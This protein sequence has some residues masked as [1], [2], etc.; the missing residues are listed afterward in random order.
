MFKEKVIARFK[1]LLG[2]RSAMDF[3]LKCL[4]Y[5]GHFPLEN[6]NTPRRLYFFCFYIIY[7]VM[8]ASE[9][10]EFC[11]AFGDVD[12]MAQVLFIYITHVGILYK[13][14]HI[15]V[16][17]PF[18]C[19]LVRNLSGDDL[20]LR[21]AREEKIAN[22][23]KEMF[24][25]LVVLYYFFAIFAWALWLY[26]SLE[27]KVILPL[28]AWY[29]F[30]FTRP[31]L[32][33]IAYTQQVSGIIIIAFVTLA[34]DFVL[35]SLMHQIS[36]RLDCLKDEFT[37]MNEDAKKIDDGQ[38]NID[39]IRNELLRNAIVHHQDLIRYSSVRVIYFE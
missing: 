26:S 3:I 14:Y 2:I 18:I 17:N 35:I 28:A 4:R 30:D 8:F 11:L 13:S 10:I 39:K 6:E 34:L 23:A 20:K 19:K 12:R 7:G 31:I 32:N 1:G 37:Y 22:D 21:N 29:P 24:G 33:E 27:Q 9:G 36:V 16:R 38:G 25:K 5:S 15:V